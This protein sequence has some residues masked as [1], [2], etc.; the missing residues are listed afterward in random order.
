VR[1]TELGKRLKALTGASTYDEAL[2]VVEQV[3]AG[4][5]P[6]PP[7]GVTLVLALEQ[8]GMYWP[9]LMGTFQSVDEIRMLQSACRDFANVQLATVLE[10]AITAQASAD[11]PTTG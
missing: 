5:A 2:V 1:A 8:P 7:V 4:P 11:K 3:M 6:R 10:Q 9:A